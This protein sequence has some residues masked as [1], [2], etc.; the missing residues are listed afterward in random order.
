VGDIVSAAELEVALRQYEEA[1]CGRVREN[2]RSIVDSEA[3]LGLSATEAAPALSRA[4]GALEVNGVA[5]RAG[6][7]A[8]AWLATLR[9][10]EEQEP[11]TVLAAVLLLDHWPEAE[12][13]SLLADLAR[14]PPGGS[15]FIA[16]NAIHAMGETGRSDYVDVL[17]QF[18]E[19]GNDRRVIAKSIRAAAVITGDAGLALAIAEDAS[20]PVDE[21]LAFGLGHAFSPA[22]GPLL[23]RTM[24][25]LLTSEDPLRQEAALR[26]AADGAAMPSALP[27]VMR[28]AA[29]PDLTT[30]AARKAVDAIRDAMPGT[31]APVLLALAQNSGASADARAAA[32]LAIGDPPIDVAM[33]I[34]RQGPAPRML[35]QVAG[36]AER[37]EAGSAVDVFEAF[38]ETGAPSEALVAAIRAWDDET[39]IRAGQLVFDEPA[40]WD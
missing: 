13:A 21:R 14:S 37:L 10:E 34:A 24:E 25:R 6:D 11:C 28:A 39:L 30:V 22:A 40:L 35:V 33:A 23:E 17:R 9:L 38:A 18:V 15:L 29:D 1:L 7:G 16:I 8:R 4:F 32:F 31:A 26:A 20:F 3:V 19:P 5:R 12:P 27:L 2:A 36:H